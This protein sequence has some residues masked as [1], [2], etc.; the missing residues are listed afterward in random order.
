MIATL[1]QIF[2]PVY[3]AV[4]MSAL[5]AAVGALCLVLFAHAVSSR[6][7]GAWW[8]PVAVL[9]AVLLANTLGGE[10]AA[11]IANVHWFLTLGLLGLALS[12]LRNPWIAACA[13]LVV[14]VFA[15]SDAL[16]VVAVPV[17]LASAGLGW[18]AARGS[19]EPS[20]GRFVPWFVP[21]AAT[22]GA[23][24]QQVITWTYPRFMPPPN[25]EFGSA[26][27]I[28]R[29]YDQLVVLGGVIPQLQEWVSPQAGAVGLALITVALLS[30]AWIAG[31][32]GRWERLG[33]ALVFLLLSVAT[34]ALSA[35]V[36]QG[37]AERHRALPSALLVAGLLVPVIGRVR[38]Q[39]YLL[40]ATCTLVVALELLSFRTTPWRS[41]GPDWATSIRE[42][43]VSQCKGS[44]AESAKVLIEPMPVV[45]PPWVVTIP[46][47]RLGDS[48][49]LP[50]QG[51][52]SSG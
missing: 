33:L 13:A 37:V 10:V 44:H 38:I 35:V 1:A 47:E 23:S 45:P 22:L 26:R 6:L 25:P 48:S 28:L 11:N 17:A 18:W 49:A 40:L 3:A 42:A 50:S 36:N 24:V 8:A 2:D 52:D 32:D 15:L 31:G 20:S 27:A 51:S 39:R 16:A 41:A 43:A 5:S 12:P 7:N 30:V 9:L 19:V 4:V 34:F 29:S 14:L 46:C 21:A